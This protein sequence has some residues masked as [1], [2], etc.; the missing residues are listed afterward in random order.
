M[1]GRTSKNSV[2]AIVDHDTDLVE[3][4]TTIKHGEVEV[5]NV[6]VSRSREQNRS[7]FYG[8]LTIRQHPHCSQHFVVRR[9]AQSEVDLYHLFGG[10]IMPWDFKRNN[11]GTCI[12][13]A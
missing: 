2:R 5:N 13:G 9:I 12:D 10:P 11:G 6:K 3:M 4:L 8:A 7:F 1:D